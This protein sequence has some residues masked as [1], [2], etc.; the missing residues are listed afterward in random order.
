MISCH[1]RVNHV[2]LTLKVAHMSTSEI[3]AEKPDINFNIAIEVI[4]F[5]PRRVDRSKVVT[6]VLIVVFC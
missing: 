3:I 1:K 2:F 4:Y 6:R 5:Y